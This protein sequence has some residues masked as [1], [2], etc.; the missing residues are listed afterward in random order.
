MALNNHDQERVR[1]YLLGRLSDEELT[2]LEERLMVED[3]LFEELEIS[4]GELVE[5]Y[6]AGE[7]TQNDRQWFEHHYLA[8][9]EGRERHVLTLAID[10]LKRPQP[11][12]PKPSFFEK[13]AAFW[14]GP[15]L[16]V[17][18]LPLLLVL[19][20]AGIWLYSRQP[21][22]VVTVGLAN[23]QLSRSSG[24]DALPQKLT[25]PPD[26][27]EL[28]ASLTLPKAFPQ[29]TRFQALL[30][31]QIDRKQV[32]VLDHKE[33]VVTVAISAKDLPRGEYALE[34]TALKSDGTEEAIPGNYRF[35][36]N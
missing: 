35:D 8:S 24:G 20:I 32:Q 5:E 2:R 16:A 34:L 33:N 11:V 6:C 25:L 29:G 21:R 30:D 18:A 12:Q 22:T 4:K 15:R 9:P 31:N 10:S 17:A 26:A 19:G 13:L 7:L 14:S 3:D 27:G 28:R 23:T 36:V 1:D